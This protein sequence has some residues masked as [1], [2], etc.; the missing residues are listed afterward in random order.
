MMLTDAQAL[1]E[2]AVAAEQPQGA[3]ALNC[4]GDL[5]P[6][7]SDIGQRLIRLANSPTYAGRYPARTVTEAIIRIGVRET[8]TLIHKAA[9]KSLEGIR[10]DRTG[11]V[12]VCRG[13][14]IGE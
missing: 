5:I 11:A 6:D 12:S 13:E 10:T 9:S 7:S 8:Q 2:A 1:T 14:S 4:F 3:E